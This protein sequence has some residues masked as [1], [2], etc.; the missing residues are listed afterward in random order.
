MKTGESGRRKRTQS[1]KNG[2]PSQATVIDSIAGTFIAALPRKEQEKLRSRGRRTPVA[3]IELVASLAEEH[4][5]I[6]GIS[7]DAAGARTALA[8]VKNARAVAKA[9]LRLARR[10]E[11]D[12]VRTFTLAA[13]RTMAVT[14]ALS[15]LVHIPE[16]AGFREANAR[17]RTLRRAKRTARAPSVKKR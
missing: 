3:V 16:N 11:S 4:G 12:A 7:Y 14:A 13:D 6:A 8:R 15:R 9:A 1:P 2:P 10:A 17:I 5:T